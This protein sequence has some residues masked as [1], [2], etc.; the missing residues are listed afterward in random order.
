MKYFIISI[1]LAAALFIGYNYVVLNVSFAPEGGVNSPN[2]ASETSN[3]GDLAVPV[4]DSVS[5]SVSHN[6]FGLFTWPVYKDGINMRN[7]NNAI[8]VAMIAMIVGGLM[9]EKKRHKNRR[10]QYNER[11]ENNDRKNYGYVPEDLRIFDLE[12][13]GM[14]Q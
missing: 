6:Y 5:V 1:M 8:F 13:D 3:S 12:D 14:K 10:V 11:V 2:I 4:T 7:F 9:V